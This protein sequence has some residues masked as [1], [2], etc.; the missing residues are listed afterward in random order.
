MWECFE[1][2]FVIGRKLIDGKEVF[3]EIVMLAR[4]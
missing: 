4:S 3:D 1:I 2:E